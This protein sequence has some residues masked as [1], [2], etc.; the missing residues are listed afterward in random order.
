MTTAS[1]GDI[2]DLIGQKKT[3]EMRQEV[4]EGK[5]SSKRDWYTY[6]S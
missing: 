2:K 4:I 5:L 3:H 6:M 1:L